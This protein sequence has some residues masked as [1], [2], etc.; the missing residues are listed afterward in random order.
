VDLVEARK[1][2]QYLLSAQNADG[3]WGGD[4]EVAGQV[5]ETAL[6]L[7]ALVDLVPASHAKGVSQVRRGL[8]WLCRAIREGRHR[9]ASPIGFYFARLWYFEKLYPIIFSISALGRALRT[10]VFH[11]P[12]D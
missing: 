6:A 8:G 9:Q 4:R 2:V 1:G 5:E 3:S 7:T 11:S 10:P 12:G